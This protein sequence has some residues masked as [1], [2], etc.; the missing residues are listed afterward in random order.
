MNTSWENFAS[1]SQLNEFIRQTHY[2][3]RMEDLLNERRTGIL[4]DRV[5]IQGPP[6]R[7]DEV[8]VPIKRGLREFGYLTDYNLGDFT[9]T[10]T[11]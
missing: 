1:A 5:T 11:D 2:L 3:H 7:P 10:G 6:W 4:T 9:L 8:K